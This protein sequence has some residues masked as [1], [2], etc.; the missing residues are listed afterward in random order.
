MLLFF[1]SCDVMHVTLHAQ[2]CFRLTLRLYYR[3]W[4]L[5]FHYFLTFRL[6]VESSFLF[7]LTPKLLIKSD[8]VLE[9]SNL[10][11]CDWESAQR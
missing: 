4:L 9:A 11:K 2:I 5:L 10:V 8:P 1:F 6:A 7:L 3:V